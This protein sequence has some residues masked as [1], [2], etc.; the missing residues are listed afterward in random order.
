MLLIM[1]LHSFQLLFLKTVESPGPQMEIVLKN[2]L[3]VEVS[4]QNI[5]P[6][7]VIDGGGML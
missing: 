1:S 3:K 5:K 2:I 6:D 4:S 7:A